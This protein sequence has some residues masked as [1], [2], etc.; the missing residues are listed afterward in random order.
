[1]DL[2]PASPAPGQRADAQRNVTRILDAAAVRLSRDPDAGVGDIA[3]EAGLAR[4][5]VYGHFPSRT[6]LVDAVVSRAIAEGDAVLGS[7][8]LGGDAR[9][10]LMRLIDASWL[11]IA[12]IGSLTAAAERALSEERLLALHADPA[13]RVHALIE[14]GRAEGVF[15]TD[16]P[17]S[18]LVTTLHRLVHGA[19]AEVAAGRLSI[20]DAPRT[21]AAT[22]LAACT[23]PGSL[24]PVVTRAPSGEEPG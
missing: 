20:A 6:D 8:D 18:W 23:P 10:A 21:I 2:A 15:R 16:L 5:T 3:K 11:L 12:Q 4:V 24:V 22:T 1:M 17:A 7:I 19:A 14:R 13:A 9:D